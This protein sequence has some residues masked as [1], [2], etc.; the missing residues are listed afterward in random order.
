MKNSSLH[1]LK[2]IFSFL[3]GWLLVLSCTKDDVNQ[4]MPT[5]VPNPNASE[6]VVKLLIKGEEILPPS[7]RALDEDLEGSFQQSL[8]LFI[9]EKQGD[10]HIYNCHR[11]VKKGE[12]EGSFTV[13]VPSALK[14][15]DLKFLLF[16]N[17]KNIIG[18]NPD[19]RFLEK[20]EDY[21]RKNLIQNMYEKWGNWG[22]P[23]W[24]EDTLSPFNVPADGA[25]ST[26]VANLKLVRMLARVDVGIGYPKEPNSK[27]TAAGLNNFKLKNVKVYHS[28]DRGQLMPN[29]DAYTTTGTGIDKVITIKS[30][31]MPGGISNIPPYNIQVGEGS[32]ACEREIYLFEQQIKDNSS[33]GFKKERTCILIEGEYTDTNSKK[34]TGWYRLDFRGFGDN[35]DYTDV[36]RSK[37]YRFNI[38]EVKGPG[39]ASEEDAL[40]SQASNITVNL[41]A[42]D[43]EQNDIIFDGQSFLSVS[44]SELLFY[45][46]RNTANFTLNTNY[47]EGTN[48]NA[49]WKIKTDGST[50]ITATP[51]MGPSGSTVV[52]LTW[53]PLPRTDTEQIIKLAA[54]NLEKTLLLRY[55]HENTPGNL[56]SFSLEPPFLYFLKSGGTG[57]VGVKSNIIKKWLST[58][59]GNLEFDVT[60]ETT[61]NT[62]DVRVKPFPKTGFAPGVEKGAVHVNV[63]AANAEITAACI[64][65]QLT[66]EKDLTVPLKTMDHGVGSANSASF[67]DVRYTAEK[68][69][70][71]YMISFKPLDGGYEISPYLSNPD[72]ASGEGFLQIMATPNKTSK[73]RVVGKLLFEPAEDGRVIDLIGY[74]AKEFE[75]K[76]EP[77]PAPVVSIQPHNNIT[78]LPWSQSQHSFTV[79][80]DNIH[81]AESDR[82]RIATSKSRSIDMTVPPSGTLGT[83]IGLDIKPNRGDNPKSSTL[84]VEVD[85]YGDHV[86]RNE[87]T[88]TQR[89]PESIN[90][91]PVARPIAE[92]PW[93]V[94]NANL[95]L[96][97]L[98]NIYEVKATTQEAVNG[99]PTM[100]VNLGDK[101]FRMSED[102]SSATLGVTFD[103][104][105]G[106]QARKVKVKAEAIGNRES[107]KRPV[108]FTLIQKPSEPGTMRFNEDSRRISWRYNSGGTVA[109]NSERINPATIRDEIVGD[110]KRDWL[111][112]EYS[113]DRF[114]FVSNTNTTSGERIVTFRLRAQDVAGR[115]VT[116]S[117]TLTIIQEPAPEGSF[118]FNK[119]NYTFDRR[120]Q[121]N[122]FDMNIN[123]M[124]LSTFSVGSIPSW[125][126]NVRV[127]GNTVRGTIGA[128]PSGNSGPREG[129]VELR[130][131]NYRNQQKTATATFKQKGNTVRAK[132]IYQRH[133]MRDEG[134]K[135]VTIYLESDSRFIYVKPYISGID[136]E[137]II[138]DE[139]FQAPPPPPDP[140]LTTMQFSY[141]INKTTASKSRRTV[142]TVTWENPEGEK[143][144]SYIT[145]EQDGIAAP[146]YTD[147]GT[148]PDRL[149]VLRPGDWREYNGRI[150]TNGLD[151][152]SKI[153][154]RQTW[155][156]PVKIE[157]KQDV[158]VNATDQPFYLKVEIPGDSDSDY[159]IGELEIYGHI[160]GVKQVLK[161]IKSSL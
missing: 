119:G 42:M 104:N 105:I 33:S 154:V 8:L 136:G 37:L 145:I 161:T 85:G 111:T 60:P 134:L 61:A 128:A 34:Y 84:S 67:L 43:L 153:Y 75:V 92:L 151:D 76:Q 149:P 47:G 11:S 138:Y 89:A 129:T 19:D 112:L 54:G 79:S 118:R 68:K 23:M 63:K 147:D 114:G 110:G 38:I 21:I 100:T 2:A 7:T 155:G 94:T 16:A 124:N 53:D 74:T 95:S 17:S 81:F 56:T 65:N 132:N 148:I 24:A 30:P 135:R 97:Q 157:Y 80:V 28:K 45:Q 87:I 103:T 115:A 144:Y 48:N 25:Q 10:K 1:I 64:I 131:N 9:L 51:G 88:F 156:S 133:G 72:L 36:L 73:E 32:N 14:G 69:A 102:K 35:A 90:K 18:E 106:Q 15:K 120:R 98:S 5:G 158:R 109:V 101:N 39:Y 31:S 140:Y 130:A 40:N 137:N 59:L 27:S 3:L 152:D 142:Y 58:T 22:I 108:E 12:A 86:G 44:T 13:R 121:D 93:N 6:V 62:F 159:F 107:E 91:E 123:D 70:G 113:H 78:E 150:T 66:Y 52:S 141:W 29:T 55:V 83:P 126:S 122:V 127:E 125:M 57:Q 160:N 4:D 99:S 117:N 77:V 71:T 41:Q 49:A 46:N 139:A 116:S 143:S 82:V 96:S 20:D 50:G 146:L 26:A